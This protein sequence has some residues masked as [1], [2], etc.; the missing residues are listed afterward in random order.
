MSP[1]AWS[2]YDEEGFVYIPSNHSTKA[3]WSGCSNRQAQRG[4]SKAQ[5]D[6]NTR[7]GSDRQKFASFDGSGRK[8][9]GKERDSGQEVITLLRRRG[10]GLDEVC[11]SAGSGI[12]ELAR[13]NGKFVAAVAAVRVRRLMG[14]CPKTGCN[15]SRHLSRPDRIAATDADADDAAADTYSATSHAAAAPREKRS[16]A[17]SA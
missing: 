2:T 3:A 6:S 17:R 1:N 4:K 7:K 11:R 8:C 16:A 10:A 14:P 9:R 13:S 5:V 15:F 12:P